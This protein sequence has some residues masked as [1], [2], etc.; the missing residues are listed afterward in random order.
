MTIAHLTQLFYELTHLNNNNHVEDISERNHVEDISERNQYNTNTLLHQGYRYYI[1]HESKVNKTE[2]VS[3]EGKEGKLMAVI[4]P[5]QGPGVNN[6][7]KI[8]GGLQLTRERLQFNGDGENTP[9]ENNTE[10]TNNKVTTKKGTPLSIAENQNIDVK[11]GENGTHTQ[12]INWIQVFLQL[13]KSFP[14]TK[15]EMFALHLLSNCQRVRN[16]SV[17][18]TMEEIKLEA[19][20]EYTTGWVFHAYMKVFRKWL[21]IMGDAAENLE[22]IKQAVYE[23]IESKEVIDSVLLIIRDPPKLPCVAR[24]IE[25]T[26]THPVPYVQPCYALYDTETPSALCSVHYSSRQIQ[27]IQSSRYGTCSGFLPCSAALQSLP[28]G[29]AMQA[30]FQYTEMNFKPNRNDESQTAHKEQGKGKKRKTSQFQDKMKLSKLESYARDNAKQNLLSNLIPIR[31]CDYDIYM[32]HVVNLVMKECNVSR[33][34]VLS[35]TYKTFCDVEE[36]TT[37]RNEKLYIVYCGTPKLILKKEVY[38]DLDIYGNAVRPKL[39]SYLDAQKIEYDTSDADTFLFLSF[40][41]NAAFGQLGVHRKREKIA[42]KPTITQLHSLQE[43]VSTASSKET[44]GFDKSENKEITEILYT[45]KN[46]KQA[47][48]TSSDWPQSIE[49]PGD[50]PVHSNQSAEAATHI[51]EKHVNDFQRKKHG[52]TNKDYTHSL[53]R[54][55]GVTSE[56]ACQTKEFVSN[57]VEIGNEMK[58]LTSTDMNKKCETVHDDRD[59]LAL[60]IEVDDELKEICDSFFQT[61]EESFTIDTPDTIPDILS[62]FV[63]QDSVEQ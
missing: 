4:S 58:I 12:K 55:K 16:I 41:G 42:E 11:Y 24:G 50:G 23:C 2:D 60:K 59:P 13:A 8:Y 3:K 33:K 1:L 47:T 35:I 15:W 27:S 20:N 61:G 31:H 29:Q 19:R 7:S 53:N 44:N 28:N 49:Q 62:S 30:S 51:N 34:V 21:E 38:N 25:Q 45:R 54:I 48:C 40:N 9:T 14:P 37:K 5:I 57:N 17:H 6:K 63:D 10:N 43:L 36:V 46:K 39:L 22:Q 56:V 52:T 32:E 18:D 26:S